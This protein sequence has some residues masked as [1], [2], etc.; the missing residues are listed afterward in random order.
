M[1]SKNW[2][3]TLIRALRTFGQAA[4]GYLVA[5]VALIKWDDAGAAKT[6]AL[7]VITAAVACGLAALMNLPKTEDAA[8]AS[9][10]P[11]GKPGDGDEDK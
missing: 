6:T 2:K 11:T 8:G 3:E 1:K 9:P 7:T 4:V 5:N 10:R